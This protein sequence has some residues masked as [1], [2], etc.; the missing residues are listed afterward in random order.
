MQ[1]PAVVSGM[2][3]SHETVEERPGPG[4]VLQARQD[5][6]EAGSGSEMRCQAGLTAGGHCQRLARHEQVLV[7]LLSAS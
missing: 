2:P 3:G 4:T 5:Y 6:A 7:H 1:R